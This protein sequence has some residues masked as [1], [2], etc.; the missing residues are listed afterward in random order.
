MPV[1]NTAPYLRKALDSVLGQTFPSWECIAVDDG[2]TDGSA[3]VLVEYAAIDKRV[4]IIT[5]SNYGP[6][7]ARTR[8]VEAAQGE[9]LVFLDS[10]DHLNPALLDTVV[11]VADSGQAD[12]VWIDAAIEVDGR[13][14]H[15]YNELF[16]SS[17]KE[18]LGLLLDLKIQGW[19]W[20][21]IIRRSFWQE[22]NIK[23]LPDCWVM[24]DTLITLQ[25]LSS[26]PRLA[27]AQIIGY[28]YNRGNIKSLTGATR[29][30][31]IIGRSLPNLRLIGDILREKNLLKAYHKQF[32][33]MVV[34]AKIYLS[35]IGRTKEAQ[36][37][38]SWVNYRP[39]YFAQL[40][41]KKWPYWLL[42][43]L[44][45]IARVFRR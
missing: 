37:L 40:G 27:K 36:R 11:R 14:V 20:T 26:N 24:E 1:Y 43:N 30:H 38:E 9:Y 8:A 12:M 29:T 3:E 28:Y 19:L 2:S 7:V 35:R 15:N 5:Q 32:A 10:D 45:P 4:R 34:T 41:S 16:S 22:A 44:G 17:S 13:V 42:M 31:D 21:K 33:S 18:M 6:V 23:V 25:L 39:S